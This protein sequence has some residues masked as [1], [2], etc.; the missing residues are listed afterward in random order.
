L[1]R[2]LPDLIPATPAEIRKR[3]LRAAE[4]VFGSEQT[5]MLEA[6]I[7]RLEFEPE[8]ARLADLASLSHAFA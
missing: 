5:K 6:A 3:F 8:A 7:D 4:P 2:R 1:T